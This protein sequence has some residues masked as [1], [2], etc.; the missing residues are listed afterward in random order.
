M[1]VLPAELTERLRVALT[2]SVGS[3]LVL[4]ANVEVEDRW[5]AG[6][7]GL[8]TVAFTGSRAIVNRM[9][10]LALLLAG[11]DDHVV[12][13]APPDPAYLEYLDGLGL[14]LPQLLTAND[15]H[16]QRTVT[17]DA[18]ADPELIAALAR[19]AS[20]GAQLWPHGVSELEERLSARSG[21]PLAA[22]PAA[23]CKAVNSKVYSRL[24][25]D[26]VGV[27]QPSGMVCRDLRELAVACDRADAWL[28]SGHPV[29]LK[30]AY[31]VSGKGLLVVRG[32][33]RLRQVRRMI[34]RRADR[35]GRSRLGLVV[36]EWLPKLIDINYQ[37]T[38]DRDRDVHFDFVREALTERG[39][40]KGHRMPARLTARQVGELRAAALALGKR[41]AADGYHGVVGVD[42]LLTEDDQLYPMIE[43]NARNNMSTYQERLRRTCLDSSRVAVAKQYPVRLRRPVRFGELRAALA[44]LLL[45]RCQDS[46]LLVNGFATV[47]A[48]APPPA[49]GEPGSFDGRLYG[50]LVAATDREVDAIDQQVTLRL[51]RLAHTR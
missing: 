1:R 35:S 45:A 51:D 9:D 43:I 27:R 32:A 11:P 4:M 19:L 16:P 41:L 42:A 7:P 30:D 21:L 38:I 17:E 39:V 23:V 8:P 48:A 26:A 2:G 13:K 47:N 50:V 37:F 46:G 14:A 28:A 29:V 31:G 10:E 44:G 15:Q 22:P 6:E 12:L 24:I 40:H 34:E 5:A 25:A 49:R 20:A 33:D 36:E 3:P 18:L